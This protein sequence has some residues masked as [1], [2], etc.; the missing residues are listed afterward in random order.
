[1]LPWEQKRLKR[2]LGPQYAFLRYMERADVRALLSRQTGGGYEILASLY[3]GALRLDMV[4][5]YENGHWRLGYDL[6]GKDTPQSPEWFCLDN[7]EEPVRYQARDLE[8]EMFDALDRA[9][10]MRDLSYTEHGFSKA[11]AK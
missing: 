5:F 4:A 6:L 11:G 9:A 3:A 10:R 2:T 8:R 7:L 1:M